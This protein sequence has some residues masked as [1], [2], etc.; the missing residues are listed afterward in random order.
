MLLNY[1]RIAWRNV[2][3]HKTYA[4][5]NIGGLA[6][7]I[8]A[9]IILFTVV[10]YE[11]SFD[12]FQPN[13]KRIYHVAREIHKSDGVSYGE[14][15]PYP[16]YDALRV[17]FP[18][19]VT[20]ALFEAY[21]GQVTVL[22]AND[23][24]SFSNKK[25]IEPLGNFFTDPNFFSV[26]QYKWLAGSPTVLKDPD[27]TVLTRKRA[28]KYFGRW[29]SAIG[30]LLKIDNTATVKVAG[31]IEDIPS[32]TDFPLGLIS[33]YE[34]MKKY[35]PIY[36]YSTGW[37]TTSNFQAFMLLPENVSAKAINDELIRFSKDKYNTNRNT[38]SS[39]F[40]FLRPLS[41]VH[42]DKDLS[43]FGDHTISKNTLWTLSLI[44]V[45]II[46]M[47]CINFINLSTAQAVS[48]S[49]EV[50]IRKVLGSNRV[51]LFWQMIGET[52]IIV[53]SAVILAVALAITC[54]PYIKHIA[55]IQEKMSLLNVS[56]IVFIAV[57]TVAVTLLAGIYPSLILSGFKP[58]LA[59]KNKITSASIG[60]ISLRRGLV[61]TQF[62]IS[63]VL[64]IGTIIAVMQMSYIRTADLG[65]NKEAVLTLNSNV[66][67]TVNMRQP[68]FKQKL[69]SINGVESV[70]FSSDVPSSQGNYSG[71]F[72][73]DHRPDEKFELF[74]KFADEDYFA[75]YGLEIIAGRPFDKSDTIR[76]VVV[77]ETLVKKLGINDPQKI[78]GHEIRTGRNKGKD[79]WS[80]VVGVVK[81]FKTNSLRESVKPLMIAERNKSYYFTGIKL[82]T[83]NLAG[84]QAEIE[85]AWNEFFPEF[86]YQS[87][88]M[89]KRINDFYTQEN[90]L[91]LLYKIFAGI[92]IFISC[93]GLYGLV[94]FMAA[95]K[96]KEVGIRKVLGATVSDIVYLFSKEFT[97]LIIV[98]F[99][100]AV[101]VAYYMMSNWLNNFVFRI[102]INVWIFLLAIVSSIVIAW[103]TVGYKALKAAKANPVKSLRSE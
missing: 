55:S 60:G 6:V 22:D 90:Q 70:S 94:L 73:Y 57:I 58:V 2:T 98:A 14:G 95:Q 65:F 5:I 48:R 67:S 99:A 15:L 37:S 91:A 88:F 92:A 79:T 10:K 36:G 29:Q 8:A 82:N 26:F 20:A 45:F 61:V 64:I 51:Q 83:T 63:Q 68:A 56:S 25:F 33:S 21:D 62:A 41:K 24:N 81:D 50:G 74:S 44:G 11:L 31:I 23:P 38:K 16:M 97:L 47:A 12:T 28:E 96:T 101:P 69:L 66:D 76:E 4:A 72:A 43:N 32:N 27:V 93:L 17:G 18:N 46:I 13:Y 100:I 30:R 53:C 86:V 80:P 78:L 87:T 49:K 9:C 77:N 52:A 3:K 39:I 59:L 103:I 75:T 85:K 34:T 71:S 7:G 1:I 84:T 35:P 89:D 42:F 40:H 19:L 102:N 54:M